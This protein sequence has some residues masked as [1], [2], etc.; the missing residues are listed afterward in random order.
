MNTLHPLASCEDSQE[1]TF[2][3]VI[4][5]GFTLSVAVAWLQMQVKRATPRYVSFLPLQ[6][7]RIL[8]SLLAVFQ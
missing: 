8:L 7:Y 5:S 2:L 4:S 3:H 1:D 6:L